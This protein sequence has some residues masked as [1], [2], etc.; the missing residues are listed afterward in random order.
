MRR[1]LIP[2]VLL[3]AAVGAGAWYWTQREAG[4]PERLELSGNVEIR[5]VN[6]AFK[7]DGRIE[8]LKVDEGDTVTAGQAVAALEKSYFEDDLRQV[9]AQ[10]DQQEAVVAKME[11]GNRS[12]DI[13]QARAL[14]AEREATLANAQRTYTRQ[15]ELL[16]SGNTPR[17][18]YD[19]A[20]AALREAEARLNSARQALGLMEAGFRAE[21][22]AAARA[23]LAEKEAMV[24]IAE[25]R[26]ADADLIAPNDGTILSRVREEGAI[27]GAGETVFVLSLTSPVWI[28][29]YVSEPELGFLRPGLT[30]E[31][32]TDLPGGRRYKGRIG[33]ISPT[34]E[35][36]PKSVETQELRTALVYRMRIVV[37]DPDGALRQGMP[38]DVFVPTQPEAGS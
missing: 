36:T 12:E 26:L 23:E 9:R 10:R 5:Q 25:R 14:V 3:L 8:E 4:V 15:A 17:R 22:V 24:A 21:D 31:I 18:A 20:L 29:S 2:L 30:V 34:A 13:A 35:F 33:F 27:V 6:L 11:A 32:A 38:V 1:I 7:V 19:D 28:R 16:K 37:D